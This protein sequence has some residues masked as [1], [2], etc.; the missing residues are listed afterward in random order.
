LKLKGGF[1]MQDDITYEIGTQ[2]VDLTTVNIDGKVLDIGGGGEGVISQ[3]VGEHVI[4][5]DTRIEELKEAPVNSIKIVMNAENL[6]FLDE[7]FD[8]V[9]SFFTLMYISKDKHEKVI[10]EVYRVLKDKGSFLIWDAR[11]PPNKRN[12]KI[13]IVPLRIRLKNDFIIKTGY[14]VS[15]KEQDINYY[16]DICKNAGFKLVEYKDLTDTFFLHFIK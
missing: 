15:Y 14:G 1:N 8:V 6:L 3:L 4:S 5:I 2:F 7:T 13:F 11:I 12:K 10:S 9:T 16:I